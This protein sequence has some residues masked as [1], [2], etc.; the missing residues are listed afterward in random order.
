[1]KKLVI[2]SKESVFAG[3][4]KTGVGEMTDSFA[5]SLGKI[6]NTFVVCPDG[7]GIL[8]KFPG[9]IKYKKYVR[10]CRVFSVTYF[11]IEPK[12]WSNLSWRIVNILKPDILHNLD[13]IDGYTKLKIRPKRMIYT[14][15]RK[16]SVK[17]DSNL[18]LNLK[19]YDAITTSSKTYADSLLKQKNELAV[20]LAD[21]DN[22]Y[23]INNGIAT[24]G[25][26]PEKGLLIPSKYSADDQTGKQ[27]CKERICKNY[28]IPKNKVIFLM[29]CQ[30]DMEKGADL[31][32]QH[33]HTIRELGGFTL[34]IGAACSELSSQLRKI[35]RADGA[36]W[37]SE[38][39]N[40]LKAVPLLAG[41]DFY[42]C[43][44]REEP[45]G[46]LPMQA[47]RYGTVPIITQTG[48]LV[49]NFTGENAILITD[50][51]LEDAIKTAF[52]IYNTEELTAKRKAC[53]EQDFSWNDRKKEY[54]VLYE[55][56][57]E[58]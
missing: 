47:S 55:G 41:S 27:K 46:L 44:S 56:Q 32:L 54:I 4:A 48:A 45:G 26:V 50:E 58:F 13:T 21:L 49:D 28:G 40:P 8:T 6:Y 35:T 52:S 22:F 42:L 9:N 29:M 33:L 34:L 30:M 3:S 25:Y 31:V 2:I 23:T 37:I 43:P 1:M 57:N 16:E 5:N 53:M 14:F 36:L 11:L 17:I 39:P 18:N 15:D 7:H 19:S 24:P 12:Q 51:N 20:A 38:R 10:I